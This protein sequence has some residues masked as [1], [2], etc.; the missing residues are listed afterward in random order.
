MQ[1][2][3]FCWLPLSQPNLVY[4]GEIFLFLSRSYNLERYTRRSLYLES[5]YPMIMSSYFPPLFC[6]AT[7]SWLLLQIRLGV[8]FSEE[9]SYLIW[10]KQPP[11]RVRS[12]CK[13]PIRSKARRSQN[14]TTNRCMLWFLLCCWSSSPS[15]DLFPIAVHVTLVEPMAITNPKRI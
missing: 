9:T 15:Y 4:L 7:T 12:P 14:S 2:V 5:M 3:E 1:N 8:C 13:A 6:L 10:W 11:F